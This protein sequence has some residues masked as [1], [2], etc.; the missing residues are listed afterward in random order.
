M[1]IPS[2][3]KAYYANYPEES[4]FISSDSVNS[5][6]PLTANRESPTSPNGD[7]E[8]DNGG[9]PL[10]E[11]PFQIEKDSN[12]PYNFEM[13][14]LRHED[15]MMQ[16]R[17]T[18]RPGHKKKE[19]LIYE[20]ANGNTK[21]MQRQFS[22]EEDGSTLRYVHPNAK[23]YKCCFILLFILAFIAIAGGALGVL[24]Y[25]KIKP[26]AQT[27]KTGSSSAMKG[28]SSGDGHDTHPINISGNISIKDI[29]HLIHHNMELQKHI[30]KLE[31]NLTDVF[32]I[33]GD[34][35]LQLQ[36]TKDSIL[37][38]NR[39]EL[40]GPVGPEGPIGPQGKL[41]PQGLNGPAGAQGPVG[42]IGPVGPQG[43]GNFSLC[44]FKESN[45]DVRINRVPQQTFVLTPS[46]TATKEK[47]IFGVSCSSRG[48]A[49]YLIERT[50]RDGFDS[51]T[52]F[53]GG[54]A[55]STRLA[56]VDN[57]V[58]CKI[59]WWECPVIH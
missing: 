26:V 25:M 46:V 17:S 14:R 31:K 19:C 22:D 36:Q 50:V 18:V 30:N 2:G 49:E 44:K 8:L 29:S 10:Y 52:C 37:K 43:P 3:R 40:V 15:E 45:T 1:D 33:V 55:S 6:T 28:G 53:C 24:A 27:I 16:R 13:A 51:Y 4:S 57:H 34:L 23:S 48:A 5:R 9:E 59:Y 35:K 39:S 56:P 47:Y 20:P 58:T 12:E 21:R 32:N 41:G 54:V 7:I 42:P 38:V 11:K